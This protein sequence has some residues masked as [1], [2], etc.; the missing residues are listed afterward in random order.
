VTTKREDLLAHPLVLSLLVHKW[1][2]F[3]RFF[4][5]FNFFVYAIFLVF[6]TGYICSTTPPYV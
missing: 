6:L 5:Y 1:T 4:Y 2:S 3:G